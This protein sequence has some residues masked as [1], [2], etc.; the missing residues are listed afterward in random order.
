MLR[1][2]GLIGAA[3]IVPLWYFRIS[4][5]RENSHDT[6]NRLKYQLSDVEEELEFFKTIEGPEGLTEHRIW[7]AFLDQEKDIGKR[8]SDYENWSQ[9]SFRKQLLSLPPRSI[10]WRY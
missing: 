5:L 6:I 9:L 1:N 7:F 8:L 10:L 3:S 2:V 4:S